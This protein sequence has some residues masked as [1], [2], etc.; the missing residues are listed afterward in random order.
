MSH[1]KGDSSIGVVMTKRKVA[2][3]LLTFGGLSDDKAA[4]QADAG[5]LFA[6]FRLLQHRTNAAF[7]VLFL[8]SRIA[9]L[10]PPSAFELLDRYITLD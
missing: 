10:T 1:R 5:G 6:S 3:T 9:S 4:E 2:F 8:L 7:L